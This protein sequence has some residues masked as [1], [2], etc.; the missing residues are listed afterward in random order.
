MGRVLWNDECPH[1]IGLGELLENCLSLPS[2]SGVTPEFLQNETTAPTALQLFVI[3][4]FPEINFFKKEEQSI[5]K[6]HLGETSQQNSQAL[7]EPNSAS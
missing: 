4:V 7:L 3:S 6:S 1:P 5:F 2:A